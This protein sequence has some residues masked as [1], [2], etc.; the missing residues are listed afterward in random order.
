MLKFPDM[1]LDLK[2]RA[3]P[4]VTCVKPYVTNSEVLTRCAGPSLVLL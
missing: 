2:E 1:L 3:L 4:V